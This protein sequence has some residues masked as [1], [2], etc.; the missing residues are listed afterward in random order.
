MSAAICP[1]ASDA[2][3]HRMNVP[4]LLTMGALCLGPAANVGARML[5][6]GEPD[7]APVISPRDTGAASVFAESCALAA[8]GNMLVGTFFRSAVVQAFVGA[9]LALAILVWTEGGHMGWTMY[10]GGGATVVCV[11]FLGILGYNL[12]RDYLKQSNPDK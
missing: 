11:V 4:L 7:G 8:K 9:A 3:V 1:V 12:G 2:S 6:Q 5:L 10:R